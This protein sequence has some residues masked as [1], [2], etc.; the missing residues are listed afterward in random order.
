M[1]KNLGGAK[2]TYNWFMDNM[3]SYKPRW[4]K[5]G[6]SH[7]TVQVTHRFDSVVTG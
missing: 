4:I 6:L 3:K 2:L 1:K 5:L 7:I